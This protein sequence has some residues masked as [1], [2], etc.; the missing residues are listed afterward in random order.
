MRGL[1]QPLSRSLAYALRTG[2]A[3]AFLLAT[4]SSA[5]GL[6]SVE[7]AGA[8]TPEDKPKPPDQLQINTT[9][10][11][12]AD[13]ENGDGMVQSL[14]NFA[15]RD[16]DPDVVS[17]CTSAL[18]ADATILDARFDS[19]TEDALADS[20]ATDAGSRAD[21]TMDAGRNMTCRVG[22]KLGG[23]VAF[24]VR[25]GTMTEGEQCTTGGDCEAG[26]DCVRDRD[27]AQEPRCRSYC[28]GGT[29]VCNL[30]GRKNRVCDQRESTSGRKIPV[31]VPI[32]TCSLLVPESCK[33]GEQCTLVLQSGTEPQTSCIGVG[34]AAEGAACELGQCGQALTCLGTKGNQ[35]C[36]RLCTLRPGA[37]SGCGAG[38]VCVGGP[39]L[40]ADSESGLCVASE[41]ATV[42]N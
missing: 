1:N 8:D 9:G 11:A 23:E 41:G 13:V 25:T 10:E 20:A 7:R 40:F 14:C 39:P 24:C 21:A 19:A 35:V 16:C 4:A 18:I 33:A 12:G 27:E 31:C 30:T 3:A 26:L 15:R 32:E 5:C 34:K 36:K 42:S 38:Q 37:P 29:A 22:I 2:V 17:S 28:C 6:S